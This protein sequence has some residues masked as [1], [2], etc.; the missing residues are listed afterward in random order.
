MLRSHSDIRVQMYADDIKLYA[1]YGPSNQLKIHSALKLALLR[2]MDWSR[3]WELPI[4]LNKSVVF[5]VGRDE[6]LD[7]E[8]DGVSLK[9][10]REVKD[11][12]VIFDSKF[13]FSCHVDQLVH[14][15]FS[16]MFLIFRNIQSNDPTV[17]LR[18]YKAYILPHS[19]DC[20][21]IWSPLSKKLQRKI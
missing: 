9:K 4:N 17:L 10:Q 19:E 11:L 12:G 16:T 7:Y 18:L 3:M 21:Q 2:I 5:H 14:K 1:L 15:A 8:C 13:K 20:G 6:G